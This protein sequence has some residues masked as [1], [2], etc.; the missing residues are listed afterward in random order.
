M[1][2]TLKR[3]A[4]DFSW[5]LR[6]RWEGYLN[7]YDG[8][9]CQ[10]CRGS[11]Y[12]KEAKRFQDE[13]Y[14]YSSFDPVAYGATPLTQAHP[15]IEAFAKRNV[16]SAPEYYGTGLRALEAE[17]YR[18]YR[19]FRNQWSHNL[20]QEDVDALLRAGRLWDFTR[21][22]RTKEQN[23]VVRQRL[24]DGGNSW[25]PE[26]NGYRPTPE[27]VNTWSMCGMGHDSINCW[28]CVQAR[29]E[30]EGVPTG[31]SICEGEGVLWDP[32]VKLLHDAW[33]TQEP[34]AGEGFQ[35]W[36][37]TSEGSPDSPVFST[38]K[39]LCLWCANN[40]TTFGSAKATA[41]QWHQMLVDDFVHHQE[42]NSLFM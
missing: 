18:L 7:P 16:E 26:S 14:G 29:C 23:E 28:A 32:E 11:G 30:R 25:L 22:P 12:S 13:W 2:R 31:C 33:Q 19:L 5:P 6:K 8:Q 4:L 37:T 38:L 20:I 35:L 27:E 39:D 17:Q 9:K 21:I 24:A 3:V 41:E 1:S 36:E 42:G 10:T 34:P 15:A 40:A